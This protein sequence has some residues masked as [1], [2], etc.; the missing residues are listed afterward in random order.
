MNMHQEILNEKQTNLIPILGYFSDQFG[1]IGGTAIALHI[2]HRRSIDF[3]LAS[4]K[5]FENEEIKKKIIK[6]DKIFIDEKGEYTLEIEGV[7]V[8]FVHYP[9]NIEFNDNFQGVKVA[10]LIT[11]A[12]LKAYALG[13]RAKWKDYVD[14]YFI[15]K[16]IN[17]NE[18]IKKAQNIFGQE[19]NEKIFRTQLGYFEDI[20]YS[21]KVEFVE[22][23]EVEP[24]KIKKE[25][26]IISLK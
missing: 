14:F 7:K 16:T 8:T 24:E 17:I 25:L 3:D 21:E 23:F 15:F 1:L 5:M 13:R 20:D 11:L 6:P 12:S 2:G 19:F 22:G 26:E 18:V 9:F 4:I 10:D